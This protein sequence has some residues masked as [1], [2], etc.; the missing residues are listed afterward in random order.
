M[1]KG[2]QSRQISALGNGFALTPALSR[3]QAG[4]GDKEGV[5]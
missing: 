3:L 2:R 5:F 4:E 1:T